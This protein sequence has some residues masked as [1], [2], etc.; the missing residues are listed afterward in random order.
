MGPPGLP[1]TTS[2]NFNNILYTCPNALKVLVTELV[3]GS[4]SGADLSSRDVNSV[5]QGCNDQ[6]R[7]VSE[8]LE[9]IL[10]RSVANVNG[11]QRKL[12]IQLV[13]TLSL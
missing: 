3:H 7:A 6:S 2:N 12:G 11:C 8:E 5:S 10:E 4:S 9:T 1:V 13:T